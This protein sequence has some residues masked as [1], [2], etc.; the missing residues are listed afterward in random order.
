MGSWGWSTLGAGT[1]KLCDLRHIICCMDPWP[2][3][4]VFWQRWWTCTQLCWFFTKLILINFLQIASSNISSGAP[5][6]NIIYVHREESASGDFIQPPFFPIAMATKNG[7]LKH[8]VLT[9]RFWAPNSGTPHWLSL[10][11]Q[12]AGFSGEVPSVISNLGCSIFGLQYIIDQFWFCYII[13]ARQFNTNGLRCFFPTGMPRSKLLLIPQLEKQNARLEISGS[14][15]TFS[16][17]HCIDY[18][19]KLLQ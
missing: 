15:A 11:A 4:N 19:S 6:T 9:L 14:T 16:T 5:R 7:I 12:F 8:M 3:I 17:I 2:L 13:S 10:A 18:R 1:S